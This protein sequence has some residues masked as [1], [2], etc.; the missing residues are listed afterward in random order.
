MRSSRHY[1][2][3]GLCR[4]T[5]ARIEIRL[6]IDEAGAP[7]GPVAV[8][9][10]DMWQRSLGVRDDVVG[11]HLTVDGVLATIVGVTRPGFFAVDVDA[12]SI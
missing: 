11:A 9:G 8:V 10:Y 6:R 5:R 12:A 4:A 2:A 1:A 7:D 3:S